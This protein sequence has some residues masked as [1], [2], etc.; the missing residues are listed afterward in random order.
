MISYEL[1]DEIFK[2]K[3]KSVYLNM[4]MEDVL[5]I[6]D[7]TKFIL[8]QINWDIILCKIDI[9]IDDF[10]IIFDQFKYSI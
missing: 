2:G 8:N 5:E 7:N 6:W 4:G 10:I 3:M 9:E 1:N